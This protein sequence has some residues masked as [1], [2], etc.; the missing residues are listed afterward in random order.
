M[1]VPSKIKN[2]IRIMHQPLDYAPRLRDWATRRLQW[3]FFDK[4]LNDV[5]AN[6]LPF[7]FFNKEN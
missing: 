1:D 2:L 7:F 6:L 4:D 5:V 3:F